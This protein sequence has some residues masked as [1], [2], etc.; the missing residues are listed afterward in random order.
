MIPNRK[1]LLPEVYLTY[2]PAHRF[3]TCLLSAHLVTGLDASTASLNA[4]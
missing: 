4:L 2:L 3:K 1:E